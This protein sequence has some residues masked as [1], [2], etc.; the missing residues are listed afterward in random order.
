MNRLAK[1]QSTS[2]ILNESDTMR[3]AKLEWGGKLC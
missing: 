2:Q 1:Q 3:F